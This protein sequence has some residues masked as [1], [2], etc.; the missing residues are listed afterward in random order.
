MP[1]PIEGKQWWIR[2]HQT[3]AIPRPVSLPAVPQ[4]AY[5]DER[6]EASNH[7]RGVIERCIEALTLSLQALI[8][9][10][11]LKNQPIG[12]GAVILAIKHL[13]DLVG[14]AAPQFNY[15]PRYT[16]PPRGGGYCVNCGN[17]LEPEEH[18]FCVHCEPEREK[19]AR[20]ARAR[21]QREGTARRMR[22]LYQSVNTLTRDIN[23]LQQRAKDNG[24]RKPRHDRRH[25]N[26]DAG[27]VEEGRRQR[28]LG[29]RAAPPHQP[30]P[31]DPG[32]AEG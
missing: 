22:Y 28:D 1:F 4:A 15:A 5:I 31:R 24:T 16:P 29:E 17:K 6:E 14:H 11:G 20:M 30:R 19:E 27:P 3:R 10:P 7:L 21:E 9:T 12:E 23:A 13:C 2:S 25:Q 26:K 8:D 18:E 32:D